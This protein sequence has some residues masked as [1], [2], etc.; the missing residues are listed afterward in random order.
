[1][2]RISNIILVVLI[3]LIFV[4]S[5]V[6]ISTVA[7]S[8]PVIKGNSVYRST[9]TTAF[10]KFISDSNGNAYYKITADDTLP[11]TD[12]LTD[13]SNGGAVIAGVA[14]VINLEGL[15]TGAKYVH[16]IIKGEEGLSDILTISMPYDYYYYENFEA[17]T[18]NSY[19][20]QDGSP[21]A[22]ISQA[23]GGSG[24][25]SQKVVS[26]QDNNYFSLTSSNTASVQKI[27]LPSNYRDNA[28]QLVL[29]GKVMPLNEGTYNE[30]A[31]FGLG[32]RKNGVLFINGKICFPDKKDI[33]NITYEFNKWYEIELDVNLSK[34]KYD[35]LIDGIKVASNL[36][37]NDSEKFVCM[38]AGHETTAYFDDITLYT[39]DEKILESIESKTINVSD[40]VYNGNEQKQ[41]ITIDGLTEGIDFD[42][43]YSDDCTNSGKVSVTITGKGDYFG[44]IS[45]SYNINKAESSAPISPDALNIGKNSITLKVVD[46]CEY[47]IDG[48]V[49]QDNNVFDQLLIETDYVFY[50][51][52]KETSNYKTS[53]ASSKTI[54]TH[55]HNW[56]NEWLKDDTHHWVEC[57]CNEKNNQ[58]THS[59]GEWDIVTNA[60]EVTEG[61]RVRECIVCHFEE[62]EVIPLIPHTHNNLADY[63]YND[64]EHWRECSCK[65]KLDLSSHIFSD[66]SIT[67]QATF[68]KK[69]EMMRVCECG[70][71]EIKHI[72]I[73]KKAES[74]YDMNSNILLKPLGDVTLHENT[75]LK[76]INVTSSLSNDDKDSFVQNELNVSKEILGVYDMSL[77]LNG[78]TVELDGEVMIELPLPSLT[79]DMNI[80]NYSITYIDG[81]KEVKTI[82]PQIK[83]G[84]LKFS[85]DHLGSYAVVASYN[86]RAEQSK[87]PLWV[88]ILIPCVV[89]IASLVSLFITMRKKKINK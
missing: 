80:S 58:E 26:T 50:Q 10:I 25:A 43:T 83:D 42:V 21:L 81:F 69:G 11:S 35:L 71:K 77:L 37:Y 1:M 2:K 31:M 54:S 13:W 88:T 17:N 7:S 14:S 49:W 76:V 59:F 75:I 85:T 63:V 5:L 36:S 19:V 46:G 82:E 61:L 68:T 45:T 33:N 48:I 28:E 65:E 51:R 16:V 56:S 66:W 23:F 38:F 29:K 32:D 79:S 34:N 60:T 86:T 9:G 89:V 27:E 44:T 39:S 84:K 87:I 15:T 57:T 22:P 55:K 53:D 24:N 73:L 67:K 30:A 12:Y 8:V 74:L 70:Y 52:Y 18:A 78:E 3:F 72:D 4:L 62:T 6:P 40:T 20:K 64:N 41:T 47:S